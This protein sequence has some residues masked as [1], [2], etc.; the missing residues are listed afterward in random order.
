MLRHKYYYLLALSLFWFYGWNSAM[1]LDFPARG[2]YPSV[3]PISSEELKTKY[4]AG[5]AVIVD[6]RSKIEYNV[7]HPAGSVHISLSHKSFLKKVGELI[8]QNPGKAIVFYCNG[9]TCLKS[10]EAAKRSVEAGHKNCFV[11]DSGIPVWAKTYPDKTLLLGQT[12]VD[13]K[14]QII[15]KTEFKKKCLDFDNFKSKYSSSKAM[16]IDVRDYIQ[17]SGKIFGLD[18][19][20][21][22]PLDKFIPN[23]V[24]KKFNQDMTLFIFDQVGKQVRWLQYYLE[25][26]GYTKYYFLKGGATAVLNIQ[27]YR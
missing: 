15:P 7:I 18:D 21:P 17:K 19:A 27:N 12:I 6:V 4:D 9:V 22:I 23:F 24:E 1:A 25:E 14:R 13:P 11:Y 20:L 8:N 26:N 2:K 16:L 10:Y 5:K 3:T